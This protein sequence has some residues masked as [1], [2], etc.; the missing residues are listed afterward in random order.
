MSPLPVT[1]QSQGEYLLTW[2]LPQIIYLKLRCYNKSFLTHLLRWPSFLWCLSLAAMSNKPN[3]FTYS[4][5]SGS[6]WWYKE[7]QLI[8]YVNLVFWKLAKLRNEFF[9][10][11]LV[12]V[13]FFCR[14]HTV[15][16]IQTYSTNTVL[17]LPFKSEHFLFLFP[18]LLRWL[19]PSVWR[20]IKVLT[21]KI[22]DPDLKK[23]H[24][25]FST[26]YEP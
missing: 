13:L 23:N 20:W 5:V 19:E 3:L 15:F 26:R 24:S 14:S 8:L 12:W 22:L 10:V 4:C 7:V 21:V 16:F 25:V 1:T 2:I 6:P 11:F 18:P 17:L 9:W